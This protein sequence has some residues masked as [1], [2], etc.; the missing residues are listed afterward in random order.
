MGE[1]E[2]ATVSLAKLGSYAERLVRRLT[3]S[4]ANISDHINRCHEN[5][6]SDLAGDLSE[7]IEKL[8]THGKYLCEYWQCL[9]KICR[10]LIHERIVA[11]AVGP[12]DFSIA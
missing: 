11:S 6:A 5:L 10:Q 7:R 9:Q 1:V 2:L 3:L 8:C 4:V 12:R